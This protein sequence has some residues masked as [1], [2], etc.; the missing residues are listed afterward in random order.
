[1]IWS[2]RGISGSALRVLEIAE[3]FKSIFVQV[4]LAIFHQLERGDRRDLFGETRYTEQGI[5]LDGFLVLY[6]GQA[7]A[8]GEYQSAVFDYGKSTAGQVVSMHEL[9]HKPV[10]SLHADHLGPG[11]YRTVGS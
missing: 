2:I 9:R 1:M 11:L 5:G 6:I 10:E 4:Q 8:P 7:V 3:D